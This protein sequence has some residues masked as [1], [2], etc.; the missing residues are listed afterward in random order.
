M[1]EGKRLEKEVEL[2]ASVDEVWEAVSTGPGFSAWFVP[3]QFENDAQGKPMMADADFGSGNTQEG[4]LLE[5]EPAKH[6]VVYGSADPTQTEALEFIVEG[7]DGGSTLLRLVQ[8][9]VQAEDWEMEYHSWGWELFFL[10][11]RSYLRYF[12]GKRVA[13][14]LAMNFT[15]KD[16]T[17]VWDRYY[18]ALGAD[19]GLAVGDLVDLAPDGVEPIKGTVD[20]HK[21]G[22]VLGIRTD[23]GLYRFGGQGAEAWGMV[24]S[25]HYRYGTDVDPAEW[26]ARWQAWLDGLFPASEAPQAQ[27]A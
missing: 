19:R 3:H 16:A 1:T 15:T 6:R 11:L 2:D 18:A 27:S 22:A 4:R 5:W 9:G 13:N 10:N 25:F 23:D 20:V 14:A 17:T 7:R 24:N 21:P 26:T 12:R 8:S